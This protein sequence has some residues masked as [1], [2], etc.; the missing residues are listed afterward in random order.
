MNEWRVSRACLCGERC[1]GRT[2][3]GGSAYPDETF[4]CYSASPRRRGLEFSHTITCCQSGGD[5]LNMFGGIRDGLG[6]SQNGY[7]AQTR[8]ESSAPTND[9][10]TQRNYLR[11]FRLDAP[12]PLELLR[13]LARCTVVGLLLYVRSPRRL[14]RR[15]GGPGG[16]FQC[17]GSVR[18]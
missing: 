8:V 9:T 4:V 13:S 14:Q 3:V 11:E 7:F 5:V 18:G 6:D 2:E 16:F 1:R 10:P 15:L 12:M 17:S